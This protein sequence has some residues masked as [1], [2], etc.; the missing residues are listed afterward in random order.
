MPWSILTWTR[1]FIRENKKLLRSSCS[2]NMANFE[3]FQWNI[4]SS[5]NLLFRKSASPKNLF[6]HTL[7]L[8]NEWNFFC[9]KIN[10]RFCFAH[11]YELCS[12]CIF[13]KKSAP[14][15]TANQSKPELDESKY[16]HCVAYVNQLLHHEVN[17]AIPRLTTIDR[18]FLTNMFTL[19][20]CYLRG[21]NFVFVIYRGIHILIYLVSCQSKEIP[22]Y[23]NTSI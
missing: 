21:F 7:G 6:L 3:A 22:K 2:K 23:P 1:A 17:S 16:A 12:A 5:I 8:G 18:W 4:S 13:K 14:L 10:F 9:S 15:C 11:N 20:S 19:C